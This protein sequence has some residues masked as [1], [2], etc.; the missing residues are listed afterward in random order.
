MIPDFLNPSQT[1]NNLSFL[2]DHFTAVDIGSG[3][4]GWTIPLAKMLENGKV[5][6]LDI[7]GEP[8]SALNGR[9]EHENIRNVQTMLANIEKGVKIGENTFHF[10]VL[11]NVLFQID[12]KEA[13]LNEVKRILKPGARVLIIDWK[14]LSNVGP[15]EHAIAREEM[16]ELAQKIGFTLENDFDLGKYH[17]GLIFKK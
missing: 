3:S 14:K 8:L 9:L 16:K 2:E 6:A 4:G 13:A 5:Y 7:Q 11:S 12:N 1:L 15:K 10:A 17:W